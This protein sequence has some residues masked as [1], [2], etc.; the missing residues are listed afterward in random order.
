[1]SNQTDIIILSSF[2]LF[3]AWCCC[4]AHPDLTF[5]VDWALKA[6]Y[7]A[8]VLLLTWL[9]SEDTV[10]LFFKALRRDINPDIT[11]FLHSVQDSS[12]M[13][14]KDAVSRISQF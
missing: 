5:T 8:V 13:L 4:F 2:S 3:I 11:Q 6:N 9:Q 7:L 14:E 12:E 10:P 1:M